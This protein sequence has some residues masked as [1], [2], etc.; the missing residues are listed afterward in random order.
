MK[1][2]LKPKLN[3]FKN[4]NIG[5]K[6][7]LNLIDIEPN[8]K[9]NLINSII[10]GLWGIHEAYMVKSYNIEYHSIFESV[11]HIL[12]LTWQYVGLFIIA[13]D[14]H[15]VEKSNWYQNI[16]GRLS[17]LCYGGFILEDFSEKHDL[18]HKFPGVTNKDPDFYDGNIIVWYINF[19]LK[20]INLLQGIIQLTIY[21]LA[22]YCNIQDINAILFW[23]VPSV[24]ASI[25]LFYYGTYLVHEKDGI[26]KTSNLPEWLIT[27]T[28]YNFGYHKMHHKNPKIPWFD[29]DK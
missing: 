21:F 2:N 26:I 8:N 19:M 22:K 11:L 29:L 10:F 14:L 12:T 4:S 13:H 1:I 6:Y 24:L 3:L 9:A 20:Y 17:L 16:L 28:S 15:H 7:N 5:L 27:I 25:Q 23:L 18:H